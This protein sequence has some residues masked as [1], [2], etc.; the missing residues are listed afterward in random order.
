MRYRSLFDELLEADDGQEGVVAR[1]GPGNSIGQRDADGSGL[2]ATSAAKAPTG[3]R[4]RSA[5]GTEIPH[6]QL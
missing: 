6:E 2:D 1:R 5:E 4:T 3:H